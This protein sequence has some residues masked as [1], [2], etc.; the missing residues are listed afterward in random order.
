MKK[1]KIVATIGPATNDSKIISEMVKKGLNIVRV[2]FSHEKDESALSIFENI[3]KA[4]KISR[5]KIPILQDLGGPKIR[6]GDFEN[7]EVTLKKGSEVKIYPGLSLGN[8]KEFFIN[9]KKL[10]K[11][12]KIGERIFLN[13]GKQELKVLK[14]EKEFLKA[15][16]VKGGFM[17][18]RRGVNLPDSELS[19][20][21]L[22]EKDKKD[23][24]FGL[25]QG[26]DF[27]ALSFVKTAKDVK[28][29]RRILIK[30][31]SK[32]M[33]ISKIETPKAVENFDE[34]LN[35]S[36]GVMV[37]RGDLAVEVEAEKVPIIQKEIIRKCNA[38]GKPVITA[39]QMLDSMIKNPVPT[40]AEVSDISNAIWDG[41]DAIMLSEETAM[42][43]HPLEVVKVMNKIALE[44]E[45][46]FD[47]KKYVKRDF[48]YKSKKFIATEDA[49]TRYAAK[50]AMD[51]K[52][53][54]IVALSESGRTFRMVARYRPEQSV[55]V[56][57]PSEKT[58][59]Q[60]QLSF[61]VEYLTE[62]SFNN[63][64]EVSDF[65]KISLLSQKKVKKGDKVVIVM[66]T[67]FGVIGSTN[68]LF[69]LNI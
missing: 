44:I 15:K 10:L 32:A 13:D 22:T 11:D 19:I 21:S 3:R 57:S 18:S 14:I 39:T 50:T 63:F 48:I 42:G 16:V 69:V 51:I 65:V 54:V 68:L 20:S 31:S 5:K 33:I 46:N 29:L 55:F 12:L 40:R 25:K 60:S 64:D 7:G 49:I 37:A 61:G 4:E 27:V 52:A 6:T 23:L 66:G 62:K 56:I 24:L 47:Y 41:T 67:P 8:E 59:R 28:E 26:V 17:R 38:V 53:K 36:D 34:I 43:L 45:G 9:Y 1:T 35:E 30:N 58:L 2:N